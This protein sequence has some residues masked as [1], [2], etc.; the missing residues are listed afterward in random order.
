MSEA[1][2]ELDRALRLARGCFDYLGGYS[3]DAL[4]IYHHGIQTVVNVL[5]AAR[6]QGSNPDFQIC[7][8]E[9][10]GRRCPTCGQTGARSAARE[11][12]K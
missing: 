6:E 5:T 2:H 10:M 1:E 11:G 12:S 7:V 8:V 9:R 4:E 3:G